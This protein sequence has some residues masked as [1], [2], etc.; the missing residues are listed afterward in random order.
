MKTKMMEVTKSR[1]LLDIFLFHSHVNINIIDFVYASATAPRLFSFVIR[2]PGIS[3]CL[4]R[5]L[6]GGGHEWLLFLLHNQTAVEYLESNPFLTLP[7]HLSILPFELLAVLNRECER[8]HNF[9][10]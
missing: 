4:G 2:H 10:E 1:H 8:A 3:Y 5:M 9:R 6:G 7:F